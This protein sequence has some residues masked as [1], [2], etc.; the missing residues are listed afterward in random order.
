MLETLVPSRIRRTLLEHILTHP[1]DRFYLRGLAKELSLTVSPVRRELKRLEQLG[2][3]KTYQ[4]ANVRF[5]VVNQAAPLFI[6]LKQAAQQPDAL[7]SSTVLS[8][9]KIERIQRALRPRLSRPV[10]LSAL[11]LSLVGL[12]VV[13][14]AVYLAMTNQRLLALTKQAVST[15]RSHVT[16]VK[17]EPSA[18]GQMRSSRWR[19]MPGT[20]GGFSPSAGD[21]AY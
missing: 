6:Q 14:G 2:V 8:H 15:P 7:V 21:E 16:V 13:A 11:S 12:L 3:L 10:V 4:E 17:P 19:L 20:L 18:S 1:D 9:P 5:Y